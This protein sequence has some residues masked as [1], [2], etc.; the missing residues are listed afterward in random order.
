MSK[1]TT[2]PTAAA[3]ADKPE[4]ITFIWKGAPVTVREMTIQDVI[5]LAGTRD[6][7]GGLL[8][9]LELLQRCCQDLDQDLIAA[10]RPSEI[11][12]LVARIR[13]VNTDFFEMCRDVDMSGPADG[14]ERIIKSLFLLPFL[15]LS[16][17]DTAPQPGAT[18]TPDSSQP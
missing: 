18:P 8:T 7:S 15:K 2:Q 4:R 12:E 16:A 11:K 14:L 17:A 10:S 13:E 9:V 3:P 1:D 6:D 5:D